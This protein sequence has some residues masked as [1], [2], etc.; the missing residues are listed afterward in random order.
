MCGKPLQRSVGPTVLQFMFFFLSSVPPAEDLVSKQF[1]SALTVLGT[2]VPGCA[3]VPDADFQ[4]HV[5]HAQQ[6]YWGD[7]SRAHLMC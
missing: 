2:F 5:C 7:I 4:E 6:R 1:A 3:E